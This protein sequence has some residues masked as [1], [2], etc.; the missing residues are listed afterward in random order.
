MMNKKIEDGTILYC[1]Y[2]HLDSAKC[3]RELT[4]EEMKQRRLPGLWKE[5]NIESKERV[6]LIICECENEDFHYYSYVIL[7]LTT[8]AETARK[9]GYFTLGSFLDSNKVS[10]ARS[11][12]ETYPAHFFRPDK[13]TDKISPLILSHI[14]NQMS[15]TNIGMPKKLLDV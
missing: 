8:K 5:W 1:D 14:T 2:L 3:T 11:Y 13:K 10:Y 4:D 6:V 9:N 12:P 7:Q 15:L